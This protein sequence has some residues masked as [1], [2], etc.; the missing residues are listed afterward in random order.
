MRRQTGGW[1]RVA[2]HDFVLLLDGSPL[3]APFPDAKDPGA[4]E[5]VHVVV[6]PRARHA[7]SLRDLADC[8]RAFGEDL[9]KLQA[10]RVGEGAEP[11]DRGLERRRAAGAATWW[12][13]G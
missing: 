10:Q 2:G 6:E 11:R 8:P 13:G 3:R 5:G 7:E 12:T 4:G 9:E 1:A